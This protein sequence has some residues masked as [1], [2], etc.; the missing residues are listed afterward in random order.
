[1]LRDVLDAN[2]NTSVI[3]MGLAYDPKKTKILFSFQQMLY[4]L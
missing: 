3:H 1:M 4:L 2:R